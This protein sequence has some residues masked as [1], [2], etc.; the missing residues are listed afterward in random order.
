[1][2]TRKRRYLREDEV[3][4]LIAAA[5]RGRY[6]ARDRLMI[7]LAYRHGFRCSELVALEWADVDLQRGRLLCRRLKNGRDTTH[8][9]SQREQDDL[10]AL[11]LSNGGNRYVFTS[12]RG[13]KMHRQNFNRILTTIARD[14]DIAIN[15]TP[16]CLRHACGYELAAKGTDTRRLQQYLGH[17]SILSTVIYTDLAGT[18]LDGIW[19][20]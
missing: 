8:P 18:A 14:T 17:R 11:K 15:V 20:D 5:G 12:E 1:M 7:L 2:A 10:K 9:L 19:I 4:Q 13:G 16:H 6:P 3:L